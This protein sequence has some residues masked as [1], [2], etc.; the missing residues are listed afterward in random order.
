MPF[1]LTNAPATFQSLMKKIFKPFLRR[2][3]LVFFDDILIYSSSLEEHAQHLSEVLGLLEQH[4]LYANAE[5]CAIGQT[6][7]AYLGHIVFGAGVAMDPEKVQAIQ[8]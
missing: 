7:V 5:K 4:Q 8:E 1:G 6:Q 3:V 2:F